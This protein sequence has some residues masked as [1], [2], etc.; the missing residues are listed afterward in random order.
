MSLVKNF[1]MLSRYNIRINRQ[2]LNC[3]RQLSTQALNKETHSFF[4]DVISYWNHLLFGD[5]ILMRR[6][7]ANQLGGFILSDFNGFPEPVSPQDI[8]HRE[9]EDICILRERLDQL[10]LAFFAE[11]TDDECRKTMSYTSTEGERIN[12]CVADVC[13]HLFNHQAHHRGQLTCILSQLDLDYGCMDLPVLV[14]EGS[15]L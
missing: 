8:Y 11:L 13:Q 15:G 4:P 1:R 6:L 3:C 14:P 7:V 12:K 2:L 9:L 10:M 5:L